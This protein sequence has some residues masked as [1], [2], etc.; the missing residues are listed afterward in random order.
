MSKKLTM[1]QVADYSDPE[2]WHFGL[3][4]TTETEA[5]KC[6]DVMKEKKYAQCK[7]HDNHEGLGDP[8]KCRYCRRIDY[9]VNEEE[10]FVSVAD[11]QGE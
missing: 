10:I 4:F 11:W 7:K 9:D 8:A 3:Y 6:A 2:C 5:R 1:W